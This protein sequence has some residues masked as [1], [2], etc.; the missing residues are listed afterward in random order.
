MYC[1]QVFFFF[2][3]LCGVGS[4]NCSCGRWVKTNKGGE[5]MEEQMG[6]DWSGGERAA[7]S[8]DSTGGIA[9]PTKRILHRSPHLG[10][11]TA[12]RSPPINTGCTSTGPLPNTGGLKSWVWAGPSV[13]LILLLFSRFLLLFSSVAGVQAFTTGF[14]GI[15]SV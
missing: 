10:L 11:L 4:C 9:S 15:F 14:S 12:H 6:N 1:F 8:D 13:Y 5:M 7:R 2:I 3:L